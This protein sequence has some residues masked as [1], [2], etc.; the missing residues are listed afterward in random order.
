MEAEAGQ[1]L[2]RFFTRWIYGAT[3]PRV[4]FSFRVES[5]AGGGQEVVLQFVQEGDL[6]D[7]P[8]AVDLQYADRRV[9]DVLVPVTDRTTEVRVP[10][11]GALRAVVIDIDDGAL[12][13]VKRN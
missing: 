8:I 5:A 9:Q 4:T 1:S 11:D 3:L 12:V 13:E 10:L 2:E 6:F 7:V